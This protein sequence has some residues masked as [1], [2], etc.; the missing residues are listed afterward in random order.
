VK[1]GGGREEKP[2][3]TPAPSPSPASSPTPLTPSPAPSEA[4]EVIPPQIPR[5]NTAQWVFAAL[6]AIGL[7]V[8]FVIRMSDVRNHTWSNRHQLREALLTTRLRL[9]LALALGMT[10][11]RDLWRSQ[12][13]SQLRDAQITTIVVALGASLATAIALASAVRAT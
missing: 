7:L 8:P 12:R 5:T 2:A 4:N 1:G 11:V 10:Q 3:P 13:R 6:L 9:L